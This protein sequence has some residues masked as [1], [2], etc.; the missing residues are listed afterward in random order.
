MDRLIAKDE[1]A[2]RELMAQYGDELTRTAYLLL[3]DRQEAEE[4]VMDGFVQAY[5]KIH[6][7]KEPEKLRPWL[8]RIVANRCRMR[9]RTRSWR[10]LLPFDRI[11]TL[12][13]EAGPGS[14]ELLIEE[15]R[16]ER[17]SDAVRSLEDRC[18]EAIVL[19]YYGELSVAE[20]AEHTKSNENTVKARLAR[21]RAKLRKLLEAKE[22]EEAVEPG[23]GAYSK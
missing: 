14:D 7:L 22:G 20:I 15:W 16:N 8:L 2:L 6:Q 18:R 13:E 11:E 5:R 12:A 10:S 21:G 3:K 9:M 1:N 23:A 17:L 19:Y 4:A